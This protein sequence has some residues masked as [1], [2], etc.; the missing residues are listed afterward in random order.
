MAPVTREDS[1][2]NSLY[3]RTAV[4]I[5]K[6]GT[7]RNLSG[8]Q[9]ADALKRSVESWGG[10][11]RGESPAAYLDALRA[12]D[13][14]LAIACRSGAPAAWDRFIALYRPVV[15]AAARSLT[16]EEAAARDIA[17]SLWADL[18]G[19]EVRNGKRRSLLDYFHGRS[20]LATWLRAIVARRHID[21]VRANSR[22]EPIERASEPQAPADYDDPQHAALLD[23]LNTV[24]ND[25]LRALPL[26]DQAR[27]RH[28][29]CD[30]LTV[31]QIGRILNEHASTVSRKLDRTRAA[32][33]QTVETA[34]RSGHRLS[35]EQIQLCYDRAGENLMLNLT[36]TLSAVAG[37]QV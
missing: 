28:F 1:D 26:R 23:L 3:F 9:I 35:E 32:L 25:A 6:C 31:R 30:Q 19:I 18:Y 36:A 13:L 21:F 29:Y 27:L 15:Y 33:R 7:E 5:G 12:E 20:S 16:R 8:D 37:T 10:I 2:L 11:D 4:R 17:D 24:L 22:L 34:L 14:A